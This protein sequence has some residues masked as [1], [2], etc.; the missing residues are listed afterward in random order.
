MKTEK[1]GG[2]IYEYDNKVLD[3][4]ANL[5]PLGMPEDIKKAVCES[6][7]FCESYPDPKCRVLRGMISEY[8]Q[9]DKQRICC[10]N[11]GA[12]I[13]FRTVMA[14]QPKRIL[15]IAPAFSEYE[16][17]ARLAGCEVKYH[18]LHEE[19]GFYVDEKAAASIDRDTDMVFIA[20]PANPTGIPVRRE[21]LRR[22]ADKCRDCRAYL[23]I[24]ECFTEFLEEEEEYSLMS[25]AG[26]RQEVIIL[27]SFTKLYAMAGLRLGYCVCGSADAAQKIRNCM[28]SW[29]VSTAA[30]AAG[31]AALSIEGFAEKSRSYV[32]AERRYLKD[33]LRASGY[34]VFESKA[35]YIFFKG[36]PGLDEK[37]LK[38]GI[39]IRNC[40]NYCGL[41]EGFYRIAV[42]T[43]EENEKLSTALRD[44]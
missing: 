7:K 13:I 4:S 35:N 22:M 32:A 18:L 39:L 26:E 5:N 16:E 40:S 28:Q 1:H 42:R 21:V 10:G 25:E 36:D 24:D 19:G 30:S 17:A 34:K 9:V 44:I 33:V 31:I 14:L 23:F 41:G 12:D 8:H 38:R 27:K 15:I 29:P 20:S 2:N 6:V 37:L 43:H 11:G 3:F